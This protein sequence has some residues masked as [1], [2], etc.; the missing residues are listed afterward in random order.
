VISLPSGESRCSPDQVSSPTRQAEG[1]PPSWGSHCWTHLRSQHDGGTIPRLA[2]SSGR[3]VPAA[4]PGVSDQV[5]QDDG[6]RAACDAIEAH[7]AGSGLPGVMRARPMAEP[8]A[9]AEVGGQ[10]LRSSL[11]IAGVQG[12]TSSAV[13]VPQG[14]SRASE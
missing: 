4:G 7:L 10:L 1:G 8:V 11:E 2:E 12:T 5:G 6:V 13:I 14:T 9:A 3:S